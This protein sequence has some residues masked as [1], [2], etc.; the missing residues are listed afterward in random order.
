MRSGSLMSHIADLGRKPMPG[1]D[2]I[3]RQSGENLRI[4]NAGA[5]Q[6]PV[7]SVKCN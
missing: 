1:E 5:K 6:W 3:Y 2:R 4:V 7:E